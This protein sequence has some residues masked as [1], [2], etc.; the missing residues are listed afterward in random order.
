[1][2]GR[3]SLA[4]TARRGACVSDSA[5]SLSLSLSD[6]VAVCSWSCCNVSMVVGAAWLSQN[7][8]LALVLANHGLQAVRVAVNLGASPPL[9]STYLRDVSLSTAVR[10][11]GDGR[12]ETV[13]PGRR[14]MVIVV[15][16]PNTKH[17][18]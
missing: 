1:M 4:R 11:L 13:L 5:V 12:V 9:G 17:S 7:G 8:S 10:L 3:Q 6:S 2:T 16:L 18:S 15:A 14:A